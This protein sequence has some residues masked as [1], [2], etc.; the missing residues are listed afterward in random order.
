MDL[1]VTFG[2]FV[3]IFERLY[4][5]VHHESWCKEQMLC[6]DDI[7]HGLNEESWFSLDNVNKV[8]SSG[9]PPFHD[10]SD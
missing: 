5:P 10:H 8:L 2:H 3:V 1:Q 9:L 4:W 6:S 7:S